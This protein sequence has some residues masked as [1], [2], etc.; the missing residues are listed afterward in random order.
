VVVVAVL[1]G[2]GAIGA[3]V[4]LTGDAER[5]DAGDITGAGDVSAFDLRE[6]DCIDVPD[7]GEVADVRGMPCTEPHDGEVYAL[8]D[9]EGSDYPGRK[10]ADREA[11]GGCAD[12]FEDFIGMAY[13]KSELIIY[14]LQPTQT[15]W[16]QQDDRE[17]VC[18]VTEP[19]GK[20][21]EVE[22]LE[23]ANR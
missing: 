11:L 15:S 14:Y 20:K 7:P 9:L 19:K 16:E 3:V 10:P 13:R 12:R 1:V 22:T 6:G 18:A 4:S 23:G 21:T 2:L 8:F 17:V 5:N